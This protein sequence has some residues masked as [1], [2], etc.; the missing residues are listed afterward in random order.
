MAIATRVERPAPRS[1]TTA[2]MTTTSSGPRP[3]PPNRKQSRPS[4]TAP[5]SRRTGPR[6]RPTNG[7]AT[8]MALWKQRSGAVAALIHMPEGSRGA[9]HRSHALVESW[10]ASDGRESP[11]RVRPGIAVS[12]LPAPASTGAP[13]QGCPGHLSSIALIPSVVVAD[14]WAVDLPLLF[15]SALGSAVGELVR[16]A[17]QSIARNRLLLMGDPLT[18]T[19]AG[20]A[21]WGR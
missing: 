7:L 1:A 4:P 20:R 10:W 11:A 14:A 8:M 18:A 17:N 9:G 5:H 6:S 2:S 3:D 21:F 15:A 12:L 13:S 16:A 19:R